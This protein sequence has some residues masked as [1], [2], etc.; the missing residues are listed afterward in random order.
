MSLIKDNL[1]AGPAWF[2]TDTVTDQD[3]NVIIA[4]IIR[5]KIIQK[6]HDEVPHSIG[7][8]VEDIEYIKKKNMYKIYSTIFVERDSQ[9]GI[10][11]GKSGNNIKIIGSNS[12]AELE[13][14]LDAKVFLDL[15]VKIRKN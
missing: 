10:I 12:R 13:K 7:V 1:P 11:I 6:V 4:E 2:D 3:E 9:R 8:I 5:E 14:M 15:S